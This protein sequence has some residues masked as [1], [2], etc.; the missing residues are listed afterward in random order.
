AICAPSRRSDRRRRQLRGGPDFRDAGRPP[1]RCG[2]A[3]RGGGQRPQTDDSRRLQSRDRGRSRRAGRGRRVRPRPALAASHGSSRRHD[4]SEDHEE[5]FVQSFFRDLC[6]L[7]AF[8]ITRTISPREG[9]A[10]AVLAGISLSH[11]LN[12]TVQALV[13]AIYP[14]LKATFSLSFAQVGLMTLAQQLTASVLQPLRGLCTDRSP[15]RYS[16][17][18]GMT[19][20]LVGLLLLSAAPTFGIIL[21]AA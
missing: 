15:M 13:P 14:M 12:D 19:F 16:L 2:A 3:V 18:V 5:S 11:L 9:T 10:V 21:A 8:V 4:G 1:A 17:V 20:T 7:R 6:P